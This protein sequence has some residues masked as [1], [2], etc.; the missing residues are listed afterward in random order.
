MV[1]RHRQAATW[2]SD[3]RV[4]HLRQAR[5][6]RPALFWRRHDGDHRD[7]VGAPPGEPR[8]LSKLTAAFFTANGIVSIVVFLGALVARMLRNTCGVPRV[9]CGMSRKG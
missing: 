6:I 2:G 5:G 8:R 1:D 9:E 4:D 3:G 7:R